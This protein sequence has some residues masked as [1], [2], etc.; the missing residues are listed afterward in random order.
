VT[1]RAATDGDGVTKLAA[2]IVGLTDCAATLW[3]R[4]AEEPA[5]IASLSKAPLGAAHHDA[6]G[7]RLFATELRQVH[8]SQA[9]ELRICPIDGCSKVIKDTAAA[10]KHSAAHILHSPHKIPYIEMCP[11]CFGPTS[12]C[13]AFLVM[14]SIP[15]PRIICSMYAPSAKPDAPESGVKFTAASLAKSSSLSPSTNRPIVCSACNPNLAAT[16]HQLPSY[17]ANKKNKAR[18]RPAVWSYNMKAHW[19]R[20]HES[21]TMP[22]GLENDLKSPQMKW[23]P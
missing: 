2:D 3:L 15:Q 9:N 14:N 21:T 6:S 18:I 11:L 10:L 19:R 20:L 17:V 22:P 4:I 13:L 16:A 5:A 1:L 12:E 23:Q 7:A 8:L